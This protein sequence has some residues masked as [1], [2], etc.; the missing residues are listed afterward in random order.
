MPD[1]PGWPEWYAAARMMPDALET[2]ITHDEEMA[3]LMAV[4]PL[5]VG[6]R[7]ARW[8]D[9]HH[10]YPS[11]IHSRR[12]ADFFM[13]MRRRVLVGSEIRAYARPLRHARERARTAETYQR[14]MQKQR[15]V[16]CDEHDALVMER[17][18]QCAA[19][20]E[21]LRTG[22]EDDAHDDHDNW[23]A[24]IR[25]IADGSTPC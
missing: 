8:A 2:A 13:T 23:R 4:E 17:N 10:D 16:V 11:G 1:T 22:G 25:A 15:D 7:L 20:D 21:A 18:R 3:R 24:R 5:P 12:W 6:E 19:L 9:E 14:I